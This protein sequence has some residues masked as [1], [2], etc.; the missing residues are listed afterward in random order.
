[1]IVDSY[2]TTL[3]T[4]CTIRFTAV[5][6]GTGARFGRQRYTFYGNGTTAGK[7]EMAYA[8]FG[9]EFSGLCDMEV[10]LETTRISRFNNSWTYLFTVDEV[11][12]T[13][14]EKI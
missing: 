10:E 12:Y 1:M 2:N 7:P 4:Y 3:P 5:E 9:P 8:S 6:A 13:I 11:T 14:Y